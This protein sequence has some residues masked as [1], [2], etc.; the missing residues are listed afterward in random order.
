MSGTEDT[1]EG[2]NAADALLARARRD[3]E[4]CREAWHQNQEAAREDLRFARLGEQW[5]DGI[6][7]QRKRENRP[8]LTFNKTPAFIRQVVN[9]ARQNKPSIKVH[10]QD[11]GADKRVAEIFD[12]L[13][14]NIETASDADVATDTAIEHAV[15]Q[16]FGFWRY[17]LV[18]ARDDA[19]EKDIVVERVANP[20]TTYGDPRSTAADSSDWDVAFVVTTLPREE[21][22]RE[23]PEAEKTDWAHDF[24][25]CPDWLDGDDV[26]VAEYW[27]RRKVKGAI[28]ALSD[29]TV[30]AVEAVERRAAELEAA[31]IHI[32]GNPRETE[33][34][35]VTQH[36]VSGA[37]VLKTVDWAG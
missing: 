24:R 36:V 34:W 37:E 29:G 10:P 31:G 28:V 3:Y 33:R 27:T 18:Y 8:C 30:E 32:V 13:I 6:L 22:E 23:Y 4:R 1:P 2:A 17:N 7:Q 21:F 12:G 5:P 26:T 14:R 35:K 16:G 20:F 11:S 9:D 19:F 15:G 25:N